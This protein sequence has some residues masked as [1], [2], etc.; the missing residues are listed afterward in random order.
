MNKR[1][2]AFRKSL[3]ERMGGRWLV[4]I[5]VENHLNPG[6]PDLSYVMVADDHETG[7]LELKACVAPIRASTPLKIKIESSQFRW[8]SR[9]A[10][11]VPSHFL[12]QVGDKCFLIDGKY[13]AELSGEVTLWTLDVLAAATIVED[14]EFA[15]NLAKILSR[16]TRRG[17]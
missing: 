14:H 5:H 8:M 13:H 11:R 12:I 9:Y 1:E 6:V 4:A 17:N 16:L 15:P 7:W 3:I 2:L 10:H